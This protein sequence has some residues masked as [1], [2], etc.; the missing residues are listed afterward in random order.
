MPE[1][2][3]K[4]EK[5]LSGWSDTGWGSNPALPKYKSVASKFDKIGWGR[6]RV[7]C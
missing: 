5:K 2:T 1:G 7:R 3:V 6:Q 4:T